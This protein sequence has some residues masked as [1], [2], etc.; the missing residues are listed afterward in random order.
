MHIGFV[1][2]G[3]MGLPLCTNLLRAGFAVT[4]FDTNPAALEAITSAGARPASGLV[5]LARHTDIVITTLP[6]PHI[7]EEVIT[8]QEGVL[9]GARAGSIVVEMSTVS[10]G[11][12]RRMAAACRARGV[13]LIDCGMSGGPKG[14]AEATLTLMVGG[15]Q[16]D[17]ERVRPVLEKMG[18]R[19]YHC[20]DTGTGMAAKLVNNALAHVNALSVIEGFSLGVKS[21]LDPKVLFDVVANS[22]GMSWVLLSRFQQYIKEG[23]FNP[24]MTLNL[25]HKD[26]SLAMEMAQESETPLFLLKLANSLFTW[27]CLEGMGPENWAKMMTI[28]E[29]RLGIRIGAQPQEE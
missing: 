20:G 1:G 12:I 28:W 18:K 4:A 6:A 29:R 8:G 24:G 11:L 3:Q 17:L 16:A 2:I 9:A 26:S 19:I 14:A 21:G 7:S 5:E 15:D 25:L 27:Y 13:T 23:T 10:P 22:S